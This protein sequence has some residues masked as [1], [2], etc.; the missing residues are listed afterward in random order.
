MS[1]IDKNKQTGQ[2]QATKPERSKPR[3]A[4]PTVRISFSKQLDLLRAWAA[5]SGHDADSTTAASVARIAKMHPGTVMLANPFFSRLGFLIR[6]GHGFVPSSDVLDFSQ[7]YQWNPETATTK[8]APVLRKSWF[9]NALLPKLGY[10]SLNESQVIEILAQEA[11]V[12]KEYRA[13]LR[14]ILDFLAVA[15]LI[16]REGNAIYPIK[17]SLG[18]RSLPKERVSFTPTAFHQ[19]KTVTPQVLSETVGKEEAEGA[20][21]FNIS[22][23]IDMKELANWKP[24]R[25]TAFFSGLAQ[26][27]S[28]KSE[29]EAASTNDEEG[30]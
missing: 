8:L 27:M 7:A 9:A 13:Q 11:G 4:L 25:I 22:L 17:E 23:R 12:G 15:G 26:V 24:E 29:I 30:R 19:D 28:A 6:S 18:E 20:V 1:I 21:N 5:A 16:K 10:S 14:M 3:Q 2:L